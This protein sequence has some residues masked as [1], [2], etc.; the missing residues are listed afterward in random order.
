MLAFIYV[1][2]GLI[3]NKIISKSFSLKIILFWLPANF[4]DALF[5]W[6]MRD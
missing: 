4:N 2:F 5:N 3:I 1:C 6:V